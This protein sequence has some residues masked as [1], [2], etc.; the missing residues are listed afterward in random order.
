M[1]RRIAA[2]NPPSPEVLS[3]AMAITVQSA[4]VWLS[5]DLSGLT[6]NDLAASLLHYAMKGEAS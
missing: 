1:A 2:G 3:D 4:E 6:E 5:L